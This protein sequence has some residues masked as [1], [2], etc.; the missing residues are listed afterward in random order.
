MIKTELFKLP[1]KICSFEDILEQI[2]K[3]V[4]YHESIPQVIS[5]N[6]ENMVAATELKSFKEV[7]ATRS[8]HIADG[9]GVVR[10]IQLLHGTQVPKLTGVD[11]MDMLIRHAS[12]HSLRV[13]LIGGKGNLADKVRDCYQQAF[14]RLEIWSNQGFSNIY[15]QLEE[16]KNELKAIVKTR[17]PHLVFVS[18]GSPWQELWID[19]HK[20]LFSNICVIGV[21]GAFSTLAGKIPRS[22]RFLRTLGLEWLYRL[23]REP[24]RAKRQLKLI[25]FTNLVIREKMNLW[26][27]K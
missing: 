22:P 26:P 4:E 7:V 16:E 2:K 3:G 11:L 23:V 19:R 20:D 5:L 13:G 25:Q 12:Q 21:G 18:F 1:L 9:I 6:A 15:E 14:P 17:K 24:W 8:I 10:A 27:F